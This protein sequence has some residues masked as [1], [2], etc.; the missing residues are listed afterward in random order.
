MFVIFFSKAHNPRLREK[1]KHIPIVGQS[2]KFLSSTSQNCQSHQKHQ[3]SEKLS[4]ST[5]PKK[6]KVDGILNGTLEQKKD[7]RGEVRKSE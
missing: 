5:E 6:T 1:H 3:K 2:T 4:Q 7:S